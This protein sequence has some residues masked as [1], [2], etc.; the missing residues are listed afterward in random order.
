MNSSIIEE[1][2]QI[3]NEIGPHEIFIFQFELP[4]NGLVL[5]HGIEK[6][7]ILYTFDTNNIE[8]I[9][10]KESNLLQYISKG[11]LY[12]VPIFE[13][14][15]S[16][17]IL[18]Q[19]NQNILSNPA[20]SILIVYC[21][22]EDSCPFF[23]TF[24]QINGD[25]KTG[26]EYVINVSEDDQQFIMQINVVFD[27]YF[28]FSLPSSENE[29]IFYFNETIYS[30]FIKID[31]IKVNDNVVETN[32]KITTTQEI[33]SIKVPSEAKIKI[34]VLPISPTFVTFHYR[35]SEIKEEI[36]DIEIDMTNTFTI[37]IHTKKTFKLIEHLFYETNKVMVNFK[38]ENCYLKLSNLSDEIS[39]FSNKP[40]Y[41]QLLFINKKDYIIEVYTYEKEFEI[42]DPNDKCTFYVYSSDNEVTYH[43]QIFEGV[44]YRIRLSPEI[45]TVYFEFPYIYSEDF[46]PTSL[47][48]YIDSYNKDTYFMIII[49]NLNVG[50]YNLWEHKFIPIQIEKV[51]TMC[52]SKLGCYITLIIGSINTEISYI[53]F[54][55]NANKNNIQYAPKNIMIRDQLYDD[56]SRIFYTT[57]HKGDKGKIK[58]SSKTKEIVMQYKIVNKEITS[59]ADLLEGNWIISSEYLIEEGQY[60]IKEDCMDECY[61]VIK[62][63]DTINTNT[64]MN[65]LFFIDNNSHFIESL[66]NEK[67]K[68]A[69]DYDKEK[70]I[71]RFSMNNINKFQIILGGS[72]VKYQFINVESTSACCDTFNDIYYPEEGSSFIETIIGDGSSKENITIDIIAISTNPDPFLSHYEITV[73]PFDFSNYPINLISNGLS[74]DCYNGKT[75][76]YTYILLKNDFIHVFYYYEFSFYGTRPKV[77]GF[78]YNCVGFIEE[79]D[80]IDIEKNV[81]HSSAYYFETAGIIK[82]LNS[83]C[84]ILVETDNDTKFHMQLSTQENER[85]LIRNEQRLF[86]LQKN[87]IHEIVI[88]DNSKALRDNYTYVLEIE[89]IKGEGTLNYITNEKI[90]GKKV[91][92]LNSKL[93]SKKSSC[94]IT[95]EET[96]LMVNMKLSIIRNKDYKQIKMINY[97][98]STNYQFYNNPFPLYF[99]LKLKDNINSIILNIR[100]RNNF[101][102]AKNYDYNN[103]I[104][105]AFYT[106]QESFDLYNNH[107]GEINILRNIETHQLFEH[108]VISIEELDSNILSQHKYIIIKI[109]EKNST[110]TDLYENNIQFDIAPYITYSNEQII[111]LTERRYHYHKIIN[112]YQIY[113]LKSFSPFVIIEFSS[114]STTNYSFSFYCQSG[115]EV[116]NSEIQNYHEYGKEIKVI[117]NKENSPLMMNVSFIDTF[118]NNNY[119]ILKYTNQNTEYVEKHFYF[120]NIS[121]TYYPVDNI[122]STQWETVKNNFYKNYT[123]SSVY[124]YYLY[125]VSNKEKIETSIC[126]YFSPIHFES[127]FDNY[128]NWTN[129]TIPYSK[130]E[131]VIVS[132]LSLE[133]E[134]YLLAYLP[135]PVDIIAPSQFWF[136]SIIIFFVFLLLVLY[137]TYTIY[138]EIKKNEKENEDDSINEELKVN[139]KRIKNNK[140][141]V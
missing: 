86:V 47:Y 105:K 37:P 123:I 126:T 36:T 125:D 98:S 128:L 18:P 2:Q 62:L 139:K 107:Q 70:Y 109:E 3:K 84:F 9:K 53:D 104:F 32:R 130:I 69:F 113:R 111:D 33:I 140:I 20:Q 88:N 22:I 77:F 11:L 55:I 13:Q 135:S 97:T 7:T 71:F 27:Y 95:A 134:D 91:Y 141:K 48:V 17:Y 136:W 45:N 49:N 129:K 120:G 92:Y 74:I 82:Q 121:I 131:N 61:L 65:Y 116:S 29:I 40:D 85:I 28:S 30:G 14:Y 119:F 124:Y 106:D 51:K 38:A 34:K 87:E 138:K 117:E 76:N 58:I 15:S 66:N 21:P 44:S 127:S 43:M 73:L 100:L 68:G 35:Y 23:I 25:L 137:G 59:R 99:G 24:P 133:D 83:F 50:L 79:E 8:E 90:Q 10:I 1:G 39:I 94:T 52:M 103:L 118:N 42:A 132:Y 12:L 41:F 112:S 96:E 108:P 31:E 67:I 78:Y 110:S 122:I 80:R 93:L 4:G 75:T 102:K 19:G 6:K 101:S 5:F 57:L 60:E 16:S 54:K 115:K 72:L 64:I 46:N 56:F 89:Q 63:Q 114:C 81:N 26:V